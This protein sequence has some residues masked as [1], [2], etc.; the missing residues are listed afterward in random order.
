MSLKKLSERDQKLPKFKIMRLSLKD[1]RESGALDDL[2]SIKR[3]IEKESLRIDSQGSI[4]KKKHPDKLG[5]ALTNEFI[6]TDFSEALLELVTPTFTDTQDC[7]EF[8]TDLHSFVY[9]SMDKELLW[10]LSMPC[11]IESDEEVLIGRYGS[12]N[13]GMMKSIYR[14][15][16][17]HRYGSKM[18]TISGIHY[19]F[20]FPNK[21]F[22]KIS[23]FKR[24]TNQDLKD[25][26]NDIYLGIARNFKRYEWLYFLLFGASPAFSSTFTEKDLSRFE[27][28]P[29][30][31]YFQKHATSL[32][33]GDLGYISKIQ[34]NLNISINSIEEYLQDLKNALTKS[35]VEYENIG[36]ILEGERIQLNSS[37]IQIEN[38]YYSTIR[39]KRTCPSGERPINI[40]RSQGIEYLELRCVDLDPFSPIGI[41]RKQIDFLD[42][43][44]LLCL[45]KESPPFNEKET[46]H[47][48]ENHKRIVNYGRKPDLKIYFENDEVFVSDLASNLLQEMYEIAEELGK[49]LFRE[50]NNVWKESLQTQKETLEDLNLTPSGRMVERLI[51]NNL[52]HEE[53]GMEIAKSNVAFFENYNNSREDIFKRETSLS[54]D[55]QKKIESEKSLPFEEYLTDFLNKVS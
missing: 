9:R 35:H 29:K 27:K 23:D 44:L 50:K 26:K 45:I 15:G 38:E 30:G 7:I 3:G 25:I 28:L 24:L 31:S 11:S 19:N 43:F 1:L 5:S 53:L 16:L 40:L 47:L 42:I 51:R 12:S 20:S 6:T 22:K 10:P 55:K 36:E 4:S 14:K 18:Q 37:V 39:P 48:K 13:T 46:Q 41:E 8:L 34:N 32:R 54:K 21:F 2:K 52:S 33:M 49:I 17:A